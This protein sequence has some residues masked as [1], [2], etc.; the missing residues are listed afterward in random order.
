MFNLKIKEAVGGGGQGKAPT[1]LLNSDL[2]TPAVYK[3][4]SL[5]SLPLS[6]IKGGDYNFRSGNTEHSPK[7]RMLCRLW[8]KLS[9]SSYCNKS[10]GLLLYLWCFGLPRDCKLTLVLFIFYRFQM[11]SSSILSSSDWS[12]R[13][14]VCWVKFALKISF[15][16]SLENVCNHLINYV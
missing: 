2:R 14:A 15:I 9:K 12:Q 10:I 11:Q 16:S 8:E 13:K 5:P 1:P 7:L 6:L 4:F 3:F